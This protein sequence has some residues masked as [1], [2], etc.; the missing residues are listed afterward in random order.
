[1][2][3]ALLVVS[4]HAQT[5]RWADG[6]D[7]TAKYMIHMEHLWTDADCTH[8]MV[9]ETLLADDFQGTSPEGEHYSKQQAVE[10]ARNLKVLARKCETYEVKVHYF[11]DN[12]AVLYGSESSIRKTPQGTELTRRLIWTDTWLKR[13]GK[14]QIVAAQDMPVS[15]LPTK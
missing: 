4:A 7:E 10:E 15:Q 6:N 8:S 12:V 9:V 3:A 14:W 11:G 5:G 13:G 2:I 1:M